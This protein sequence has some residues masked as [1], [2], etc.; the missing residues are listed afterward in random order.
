MFFVVTR[1]LENCVSFDLV[2][3]TQRAEAMIPA[4]V[5]ICCEKRKSKSFQECRDTLIYVPRLV[6]R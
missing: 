4:G 5:L 1:Q 6:F 3:V 2:H